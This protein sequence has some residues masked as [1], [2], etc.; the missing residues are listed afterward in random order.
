LGG[1]AVAKLSRKSAGRKPV[2]KPRGRR[3]LKWHKK[4]R[5]KLGKYNVQ[6]VY[7]FTDIQNLPLIREHG[8]LY[9]I[10][11]LKK[12]G[13]TPPRP[14]G[15]D[16]SQE[17]DEFKG[18]HKYVHLC[19]ASKHPME[20]RAVEEGRIGPTRFLCV[21]AEVLYRD[22]VLFSPD[23][24]NKS[25]VEP[26]AMG[27]AVELIDLEILKTRTAWNDPAIQERLQRAEKS[28]ILVPNFIELDL[29]KG[30]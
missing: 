21:D 22:G 23:V 12:R 11:G 28:E 24:S 26:V 14:G 10:E 30:L 17:A 1:A 7:H 5:E 6:Y 20:Y 27:D 2:K 4:L 9:S 19:L 3:S 29:I 8:G 25:G 15:N 13:I 16:W 18:L